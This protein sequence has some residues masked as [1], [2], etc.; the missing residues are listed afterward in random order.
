MRQLACPEALMRWLVRLADLAAAALAVAILAALAAAHPLY[1]LRLS[2]AEPPRALPMPVRGVAPERV[3][4]TWHAARGGSRVHEGVDVF[5]PR[6]TPVVATTRG[7]VLHVGPNALGGNVVW[8][9]GPGGQRHY[10]AHLDRFAPRV[11]GGD[12][13]TPGDVLGFVGN[14]GNARGTPPHLHYGIYGMR[15]AIDPLPLLR[16]YDGEL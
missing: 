15:G 12:R 13:V 1:A 9:L 11:R 6:G 14:T 7:I 16:A 3:A 5:A 2:L 4:D 10:Y 8:V